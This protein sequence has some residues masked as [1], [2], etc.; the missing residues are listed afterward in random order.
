M[1]Q[2]FL[3]TPEYLESVADMRV[4]FTGVAAV[5]LVSQVENL[6]T[7]QGHGSA[8]CGLWSASPPAPPPA[9]PPHKEAPREQKKGRSATTKSKIQAT[10]GTVYYHSNGNHAGMVLLGTNSGLLNLRWDDESQLKQLS[11]FVRAWDNGAV[12]KVEYSRESDGF[13]NFFTI[14]KATFTGEVNSS[15]DAASTLIKKY[16]ELLARRMYTEAYELFNEKQKAQTTI[17]S[18]W[19]NNSTFTALG[20]IDFCSQPKCV[21]IKI[22]SHDKAKIIIHVNTELLKKRGQRNCLINIDTCY[23]QHTVINRGGSWYID[24]MQKITNDQWFR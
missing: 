8:P 17:K 20:D 3:V 15:I 6:V 7:T 24:D 12:W 10:T 14:D 13:G 11:D 4:I 1:A 5:A 22:V 21:D 2:G 18:L 23:Y 19:Q 9:P 16:Y